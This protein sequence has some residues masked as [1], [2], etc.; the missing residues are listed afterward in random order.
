MI[1]SYLI[2]CSLKEKGKISGNYLKSKYL[3]SYKFIGVY[4]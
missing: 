3:L 1:N 2:Y 4:N